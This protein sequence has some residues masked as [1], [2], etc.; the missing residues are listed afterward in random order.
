[1][2]STFGAQALQG[3]STAEA[4]RRLSTDGANEVV[5]SRDPRITRIAVRFWA[6]IPWM[7]EAAIG[8]QLIT[9]ELIE[10]L[11]IGALLVFNVVLGL[12]QEE[13]A[14]GVLDALK[15]KLAPIASVHRDGAWTRIPAADIVTGDL[16]QLS[17]GCVVPADLRILTGSVLLDQ[18]MLT[19]ESVP[20][21]AG[22]G[23]QAYAGALVRRG[24]AA[25]VVTATGSRTYFGAPQNWS[26]SPAAKA[27]NS[28]P[29]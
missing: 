2:D 28:A 14:T 1:M 15:Q 12:I 5:E 7:L 22:A 25:G 9:G 24:S 19:G 16:V 29:S 11:I 8:L 13:R 6:P 20:I 26:K 23:S 18:S 21:E 27:P 3:L 4:A 10:A 17:L